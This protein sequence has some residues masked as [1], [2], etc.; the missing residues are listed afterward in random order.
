VI[1]RINQTHDENSGQTG[2]I[3]DF[4]YFNDKFFAITNLRRDDPI[5]LIKPIFS[6]RASNEPD[7]GMESNVSIESENRDS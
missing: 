7:S 5:A 6:V 2:H 4:K 1:A 3:I